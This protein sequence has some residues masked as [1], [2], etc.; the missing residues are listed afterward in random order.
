MP[1]IFNLLKTMLKTSYNISGIIDA[2][3]KKLNKK[4]IKVWLLFIVFAIAI[5]LSYMIINSLKEIGVPQFFLELYFLL[6]QIL[7]MFQTILLVDRKS[8]V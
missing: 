7:V 4:S 3:T 6:L 1:K 5:Y 8:V 2:D